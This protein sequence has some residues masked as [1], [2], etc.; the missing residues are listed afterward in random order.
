MSKRMLRVPAVS[1]R[2]DITDQRT[3]ELIRRRMLPGVVRIG[4]QIRVDEEVLEG[5]IKQGGCALPN[6]TDERQRER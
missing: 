2:L 4:R 5:W 1:E 6:P 3:W